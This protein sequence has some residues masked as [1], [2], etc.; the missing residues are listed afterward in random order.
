MSSR[1]SCRSPE[2]SFRICGG[3]FD[4]P[5]LQRRLGELDAEMARD[6]FWN[7]REQAQRLIDEAASLR[8]K[9][10]PL[11]TAEKQLDD[12]QVMIE[13]A[14]AEPETEQRKH[15]QDL[16]RDLAKFTKAL[17]ALELG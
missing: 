7:N 10:D 15:A 13:L 8:K 11:L 16:Q 3:F 5:T 9:V 17:D 14:E 6:T 4:V 12:F 1:A 2:T